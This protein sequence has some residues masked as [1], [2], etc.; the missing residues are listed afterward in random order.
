M[1]N[2]QPAPNPMNLLINLLMQL[3]DWLTHLELSEGS[4]LELDIGHRMPGSS[5]INSINKNDRYNNQ[6]KTK[7]KPNSLLIKLIMQLHHWLSHLEL[8][9]GFVGEQDVGQLHSM[10]AF[11]NSIFK[12]NII[13]NHAI[14]KII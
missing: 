4:I 5:L 11:S 2:N 7:M 13:N 14:N 1:K 10:P 8:S 3:L 12:E 6:A 9:G